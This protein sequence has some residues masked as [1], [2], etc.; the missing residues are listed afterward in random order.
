MEERKKAER[1][2]GLGVRPRGGDLAPL[3]AQFWRAE[4]LGIILGYCWR[5]VFAVYS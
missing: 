2:L 3:S 1:Y 5:G 4:K